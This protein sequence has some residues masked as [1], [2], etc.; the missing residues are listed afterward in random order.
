MRR[1]LLFPRVSDW[2]RNAMRPDYTVC[3]TLRVDFNDK[4]KAK[5]LK[6]YWS[7]DD[8]KW[9]KSF[10]MKYYRNEDI[11]SFLRIIK[12]FMQT[13]YDNDFIIEDDEGLEDLQDAVDNDNAI[14]EKNIAKP[15]APIVPIPIDAHIDSGTKC[16]IVDDD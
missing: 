16:L 4:D 7:P 15:M 5:E 9:K 12:R 11:H 1:G 3:L 8:K 10:D 2:M 13:C 14:I 6:C